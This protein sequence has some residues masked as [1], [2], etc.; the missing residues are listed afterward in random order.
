VGT[1]DQITERVERARAAG[2][3]A[4]ILTVDWAFAS[5]RDWGQP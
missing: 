3:T 1:R 5:R 4:L 2:G